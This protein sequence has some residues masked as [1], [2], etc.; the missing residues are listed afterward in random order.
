MIKK[1]IIGSRGSDLALWQAN[2][3]QHQLASIGADSEIRIITT[4]GDRIQDLSFDKIEGKGF[5]TKEIEEALLR[6]EIDVAVHSHKDLETRNPAGLV[7]A[8]V[9]YRAAPAELLLIRQDCVDNTLPLGFRMNAIV[10]TS[11]ARRKAQVKMLRPDIEIR[12]I[13]GNVPTRIEKLRSGA[14]DAI[15]LASA[16]VSR[17]GLDVSDLAAHTL[18]P[19]VFIPAPAQGVLAYQ[20]REDDSFILNILGTL[21]NRDVAAAVAIE[22]GILAGFGGGCHI[23]IGVYAEPQ[24]GHFAVRATFATDWKEFSRRVRFEA[25]DAEEA[26]TRFRTLQTSTLPSTLFISRKLENTSLIKRAC[27][28]W[29]ISLSDISLIET[30]P[31]PFEVPA[32]YDWLFFSSSNAVEF[33]FRGVQKKDVAG[34]SI[35]AIGTS[36]AQTL[37]RYVDHVDF[38]GNEASTRDIAASFA[39]IAGKET[40]LFPGS[41]IS[42][43]SIQA[44][45]SPG[46][47][48]NL[49]TYRTVKKELSLGHHDAYIFTSPSNTSAF[50][51]AGNQISAASKVI[52]IG[53][54]TAETLRSYG[55][56]PLVATLPHEAEL[57]ALIGS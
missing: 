34:K 21:H 2:F 44:A 35:A 6:K 23:P 19:R 13:R 33:F 17:L 27:A 7:V 26:T 9:S 47:V 40:V 46:Q 53:E 29:S 5:F 31:Q 36:T 24:N 48:R 39:A 1:I 8:A 20:C 14:F 54:T 51:E 42:R 3:L 11:S 50:F 28:D 15:L 57:L 56:A 55:F 10:G 16:G 43:E 18:D 37:Y 4:K 30:E 32:S 12:D 22:R 41:H 38:V 45:L 52:A 25:K 49:C